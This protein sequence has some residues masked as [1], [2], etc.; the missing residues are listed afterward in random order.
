MK[1]WICERRC[2]M[3][4][5]RKRDEV[6][7]QFI[8]ICLSTIVIYL[9]ARV[10]QISMFIN[11]YWKVSK[12][13]STC[14]GSISGAGCLTCNMIDG[15][16]PNYFCQKSP[17]YY[18]EIQG[19]FLITFGQHVGFHKL[20]GHYSSGAI[21]ENFKY[22]RHWLFWEFTGDRWNSRTYGQ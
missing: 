19:I 16:Q 18:P 13:L 6:K 11:M 10:F 12:S 9:A 4:F 20:H 3:K 15:N 17:W 22:P 5:H 2:S 1:H 14:F 8:P 7:L 21:K